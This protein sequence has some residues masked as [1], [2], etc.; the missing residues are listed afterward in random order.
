MM[1]EPS[2]ELL[3]DDPN[4]VVI[5]P[6]RFSCAVECT[7]PSRLLDRAGVTT[8]QWMHRERR[9]LVPIRDMPA[10]IAQAERDR[11]TVVIDDR[12]ALQASA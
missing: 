7:G 8:R 6:L 1:H 9:Y 2:R 5:S 3:R 10:V 11:R 12:R 4:P